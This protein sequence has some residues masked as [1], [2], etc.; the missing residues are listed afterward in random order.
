MI[1]DSEIIDF[2]QN[3]HIHSRCIDEQTRS[4]T[5]TRTHTY[6]D[7]CTHARVSSYTCIHTH[8]YTRTYT[9]IHTHTHTYTR[10]VYNVTLDP[11][12]PLGYRDN[13][14]VDIFNSFATAAFRFGHSLIQGDIHLK[15][16]QYNTIRSIKL[17]QV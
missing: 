2:N 11:P 10:R 7:T 16:N 6:T 14:K 13:S 5:H 3:T 12:P 1:I 4:H 17:S 15:D 9:H 8:T